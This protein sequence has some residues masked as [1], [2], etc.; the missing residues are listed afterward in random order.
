MSLS[1][2]AKDA[3]VAP[4]TGEVFLAL[5][6]I[7]HSSLSEP[8]RVVNN[9]SNI[10]HNGNTYIAAAF[11]LKLPSQQDSNENTCSLTIDNVDRT[12]I[13]AVRSINTPA[14]VVAKI[15]LADTPDVVED[16]PYEMSLRNVT[17]TVGSITGQLVYGVYL[18]ENLGTVRYRNINFPGLY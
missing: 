12:I 14:T 9:I 15:I 13:N 8:I 11:K 3:I 17:Y 2:R 1:S 10:T 7:T 5:L 4:Q 16:G 6:E 18:L